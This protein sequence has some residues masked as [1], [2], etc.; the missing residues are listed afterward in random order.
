M[1]I[2]IVNSANSGFSSTLVPKYL[3]VK[4][5]VYTTNGKYKIPSYST[6]KLLF[7]CATSSTTVIVTP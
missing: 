5:V 2:D 1:E 3:N 6:I 4:M 7:K